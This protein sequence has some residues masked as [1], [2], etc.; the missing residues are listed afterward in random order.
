[1][2]LN[3]STETRP[4]TLQR[5]LHTATLPRTTRPSFARLRHHEHNGKP[6]DWRPQRRH[7]LRI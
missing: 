6:R 5:E 7:W 3:L 2:L 1:M 4:K